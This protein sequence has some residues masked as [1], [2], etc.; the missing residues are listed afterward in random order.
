MTAPTH[1][2]L[3]TV[4]PR[5]PRTYI[6]FL[7]GGVRVHRSSWPTTNDDGSIAHAEL[8]GPGRARGGVMLG[9]V[10]DRRDNGS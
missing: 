5:P 3:T 4:R 10:R 8:A 6:D 1:L 7:V 2:W 9:T